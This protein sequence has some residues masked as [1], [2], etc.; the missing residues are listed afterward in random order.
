VADG[1]PTQDF[2][3]SKQPAIGLMT[4]V[5]GKTTFYVCRDFV[6]MPPTTEK[7]KALTLLQST[8]APH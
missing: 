4:P 6:C 8:D 3:A 1:G 7:E 5:A 2:L